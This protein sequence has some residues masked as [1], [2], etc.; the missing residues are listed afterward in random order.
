MIIVKLLGGLGNQMFQYAIARHLSKKNNDTL[1]IDSSFLN[2]TNATGYTLRSYELGIFSI[3][4]GILHKEKYFGKKL[5]SRIRPVLSRTKYV[6]EQSFKFAPEIFN[7]K[8]NIYLEGYWQTEKYFRDIA[9]TIRE[10]FTFLPALNDINTKVAAQI[11]ACNAVSIHVRRTDYVG[12]DGAATYHSICS[13]AYYLNAIEQICETVPDAVFFVFSDD[14]PW[15]KENIQIKY[16]HHFIDHNS[17][18]QSYIDM[19]L[20]SMCKHHIIA[21]SSFSWWGAWLN[22]HQQKT[23]IAP[24]TWFN[25]PD[26]DTSDILPESWLKL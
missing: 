3:D 26:I 20:M 7:I 22:N 16:P 25:N 13:A 11:K 8:G 5:I 9:D 23:V 12:A 1:I 10:D 2:I 15:V 14:I 4:A 17:G 21:N 19:Q 6:N 18:K 24:K